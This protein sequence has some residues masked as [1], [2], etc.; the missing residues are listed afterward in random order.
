M[1]RPV[2][3]WCDAWRHTGMKRAGA[4]TSRSATRAR[5]ERADRRRKRV[6]PPDGKPSRGNGGSSPRTNGRPAV[7][8]PD[9][10]S[11][12][13]VRGENKSTI[14]AQYKHC[15]RT[16]FSRN[17]NC[18]KPY[19]LYLIPYTSLPHTLYREGAAP[20]PGWVNVG[21]KQGI[22]LSSDSWYNDTMH[23]GTASERSGVVPYSGEGRKTACLL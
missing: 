17:K 21:Q 12:A 16:V 19:T 4:G 23:N 10:L 14:R 22:F 8:A 1:P 9:A 18:L 13:G 2:S 7:S 20:C 6:S 11:A 5:T 3:G 15:A